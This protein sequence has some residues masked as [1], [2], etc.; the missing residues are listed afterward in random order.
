L[1]G[2]IFSLRGN[3]SLASSTVT[4]SAGIGIQV[5]SS[6]HDAVP[7]SQVTLTNSTVSNHNGN[8]IRV[9][10]G[11]V[12]LINS[13]VSGNTATERS[14]FLDYENGGGIRAPG[15]TLIN[16]T[17]SG[18]SAEG[19]GGGIW[20]ARVIIKYSTVTGNH[21]AGIGGGIYT[22]GS[23]ANE[24]AI[25]SSIIAGNTTGSVNPDL[26]FS[27]GTPVINY[28]LIGDKAGTSLTEAQTADANG[29]LIGNSA[30]GGV[31]DPRLAPLADNGGPT[32]THALLSDSPAID[33]KP[34]VAIDPEQPTPE[35]DYQLNA[36]L[37][38]AL[39]GPS[40]VTL[41]GTLTAT[42]YQFGP[43]QGLNLSSALANPADYAIELV[44]SWNSLSGSWQKI[45]D[46]HNLAPDIGLYTLGNGLQFM[47]G[48]F[49]P[50]LF[51]A[52]VTRHLVLTRDDATNVVRAYI[53]G[54]ERWNFV[55]NAGDAVFDGTDDVVRFFQDD[56]A[57]GQT[58]AQSGF[59][60]RIR[61]F[62]GA[63]SAADVAALFNP[64]PPPP[65]DVPPNDQRGAPFAR[66]F[67]DAIDMGAFE[68]QPPA[69][70]GD[71]NEDRSIDAADH[72]LY[73]K[74]FGTSVPS[75]SYADS[76]GD[77][78][79]TPADRDPWENNFGSVLDVMPQPASA[80]ILSAA[81]QSVADIALAPSTSLSAAKMP[82]VTAVDAALMEPALFAMRPKTSVRDM[83]HASG[84]VS[85]PSIVATV[86][87]LHLLDASH[88]LPPGSETEQ[89]CKGTD[90]REAEDDNVVAALD[91]ALSRFLPTPGQ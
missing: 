47:N 2:G 49:T 63:L 30:G 7:P 90:D 22:Y 73:R 70:Y 33:A 50:N 36:S 35:H 39:G 74:L 12:T 18:N 13:T 10:G 20:A 31:I 27:P 51:T 87:L 56:T 38:D 6:F 46:F 43:N 42:G 66:V 14:G 45:I 25:S 15:V 5:V 17:V 48:A 89:V 57:S 61:I 79:I 91:E 11:S 19:D 60:D 78:S 59:V 23:S 83:R 16:S 64:P 76:D 81:R 4:G 37:T 54:V 77:G 8:G 53:D 75:Y 84:T 85:I 55:D 68:L 44:F 9:Y 58:E 69:S 26:R 21:A 71:F 24:Q 86:R 80:S 52:G 29:N 88:D 3:V 32:E 1:Y 62:D 82:V 40:L 67:N 34:Y 72:V 65:P 28:S 41:G